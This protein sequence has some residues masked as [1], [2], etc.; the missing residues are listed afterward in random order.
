[1]TLSVADRL[2]IQDL[3]GRFALAVDVEGPD[4]YRE[5]FVEDSSF[6]IEAFQID[7]HGRETIIQWVKDNA[8]S[9]P[10][11]LN[12]VQSNFVID[13]DG[14]G[15]EARVRCIS[16]AIQSHE[17]EVKHY[18]IGRYDETMIKTNEGWRLKTH[19]L[20]VQA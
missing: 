3:M 11:G 20:Q 15:E 5:I 12:H 14:D 9:F 4:A 13:G 19:R 17:G 8:G 2:E 16:Q 7:L 6:T 1:M 18:V 10:P